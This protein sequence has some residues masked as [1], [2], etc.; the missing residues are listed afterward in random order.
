MV[1]KDKV[2]PVKSKSNIQPESEGHSGIRS[3]K[4]IGAVPHD[5]GSPSEAPWFKTNIYNFQDVSLWKD[6]GPKFILQIYR[7]YL[8]TQSR[9]FLIDMYPVV[10]KV[11]T[12]TELFDT[13]GDGMIENQGFPDQTYDIWT[14]K[15]VHAY[16]GGLWLAAVAAVVCMAALVEDN[17]MINYYTDVFQRGRRVYISKLWNGA[18]FNYDSSQS[19]YHDSIMADMLAGQWYANVCNLGNLFPS[20]MIHSCI[21]EIFEN[22]VI[23]FGK[24][25]LLGAV[26]GMR[27][28]RSIDNSCLQSREVWTGT[29]YA[30][31]GDVMMSNQLV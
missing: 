29:T 3:R 11:I 22:N 14:A 4:V 2:D 20:H 23:E 16:S 8:F 13:D 7:D 26:N 17:H 6:L 30:L 12:R 5:L 27:P 18:Y 31:A 9:K 28:N 10:I 24:G 19:P 21:R 1:E 15:G 25:R